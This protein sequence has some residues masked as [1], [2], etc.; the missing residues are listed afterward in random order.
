MRISDTAYPIEKDW[1]KWVIF[2]GALDRVVVVFLQRLAA[3]SRDILKRPIHF[4]AGFRTYDMQLQLWNNYKYNG[5]PYANYPGNSWHEFS[6]ACDVHGPSSKWGEIMRD[7]ILPPGKQT[8][9]KYGIY[10]TS[11]AGTQVREWW[12]LMPMEIMS[13]TGTKSTFLTDDVVNGED[14]MKLNDNGPDVLS[15][16]NALV[17]VGKWALVDGVPT[18]TPN[19]NFGPTTQAN[20]NSFKKS[21]GLPEDGIVNETT[22]A[23]MTDALRLLPDQEL[24][25]ANNE[26]KRLQK[27]ID[28]YTTALQ[29]LH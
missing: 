5:G 7:Y 13:Y 19:S 25:K 18:P 24:D 14:E 11:W 26:V 1:R 2:D 3:Y 27:L 6:C 23:K 21:I 16:Q 8:M 20:T 22:W 9:N 10:I 15:W 28:D 12:H 17:K 29:A 4:I